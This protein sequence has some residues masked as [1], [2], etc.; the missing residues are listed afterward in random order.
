MNVLHTF[1]HVWLIHVS[2]KE[3]LELKAW[4]RHCRAAFGNAHT[5]PNPVFLSCGPLQDSMVNGPYHTQDASRS[6]PYSRSIKVHT[7][8]K[9]YQ[10]QY[11]AQGPS[12]SIPYS[13]H[14]RPT[15]LCPI[16]APDCVAA[17]RTSKRKHD[18]SNHSLVPTPAWLPIASLHTAGLQHT[19]THTHR[20]TFAHSDPHGC[21]AAHLPRHTAGTK[22]K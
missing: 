16:A 15:V 6:I 17:H 14:A 13:F 22:Y 18:A 9:I 19:H 12:R 20:N 3:D 11:H 5:P 21:M 4:K 10:G 1:I 7:I 8:L 2:T